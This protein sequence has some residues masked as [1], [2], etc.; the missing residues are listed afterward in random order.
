[1]CPESARTRRAGLLLPKAARRTARSAARLAVAATPAA[2]PG[3]QCMGRLPVKLPV[4]MP[5]MFPG[6]AVAS[7]RRENTVRKTCRLYR[8]G[9]LV[10]AIL[11]PIGAAL[12]SGIPGAS[13]QTVDTFCFYSGG[14]YACPNAWNGGPWVDASAGPGFPSGILPAND[15]FTIVYES[16]GDAELQDSGPNAWAG[17]CI[18][19]AYNESGKAETSLDPCG[20][21]GKNA[22]W[23]TTFV[24][25]SQGCPLPGYVAFYNLHWGGYLGPPNKWVNGSNLYLNKPKSTIICFDE[26]PAL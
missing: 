19:D 26:E 24:V 2:R 17:K 1:M 25:I 22:G 8:I 23:G 21:N 10:G 13:A 20:V 6:A 14:G 16:N 7:S 9:A 11:L 18:G 4:K 12:A 3:H 15:D 5:G